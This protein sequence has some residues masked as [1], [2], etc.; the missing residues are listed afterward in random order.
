M[1]SGFAEYMGGEHGEPGVWEET[2]EME[3]R[4]DP[5]P[6]SPGDEWRQGM[7]RGVGCKPALPQTAGCSSCSPNRHQAASMCAQGKKKGRERGVIII[8][9]LKILNRL[10]N[11]FG[12]FI[13]AVDKKSG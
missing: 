6:C 11:I 7:E 1:E 5:T 3:D 9:A 10:T 8:P 13:W 4:E 2:A 12:Q